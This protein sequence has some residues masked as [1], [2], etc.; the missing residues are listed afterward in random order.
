M[1][2][3]AS[4]SLDCKGLM[5]LIDMILEDLRTIEILLQDSFVQELVIQFIQ[6][7]HSS[8][9]VCLSLVVQLFVNPRTTRYNYFYGGFINFFFN[10]LN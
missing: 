8:S 4:P 10:N 2:G 9:N 5:V 7:L 3:L 6:P 1:K